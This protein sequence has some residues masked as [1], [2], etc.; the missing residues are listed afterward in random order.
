MWFF[1]TTAKEK[2]K[3]KK[4]FCHYLLFF[5]PILLHLLVFSDYY[6]PICQFFFFLFSTPYLGLF[7]FFFS[8]ISTTDIAY[9]RDMFFFSTIWLAFQFLY[10]WFFFLLFLLETILLGFFSFFFYWNQKVYS[11]VDCTVF[12]T[13]AGKERLNRNLS[14]LSEVL[15]RMLSDKMHW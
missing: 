11:F 9:I 10:F 14:V 3:I 6:Q 15:L 2:R 4:I 12:V 13:E 1:F 8:Y 7:W 5:T